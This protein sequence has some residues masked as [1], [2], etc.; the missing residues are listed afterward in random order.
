VKISQI[1]S[2]FDSK[3]L[4]FITEFLTHTEVAVKHASNLAD[5]S[6]LKKQ[7]VSFV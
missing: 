6:S 4:L 2:E 1:S 3:D 5:I 7:Q